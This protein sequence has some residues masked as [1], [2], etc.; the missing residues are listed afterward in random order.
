MNVGMKTGLFV[1]HVA[2]AALALFAPADAQAYVYSTCEGNAIK[3]NSGWTNMHI[4]TTS[5][6]AGSTWDS[7]LQNA[8]WHWNN[9]KGSG[10]NYYVNRDTDGSHNGDNGVNEIY[11][12]SSISGALAVT[13]TR[14]HCYWLFGYQYG[15]DET[16]IGFNSNY[17]WTTGTYSYSSPTGSPYN[18]EAV[19]LHE[20][21]HALGLKHEDARMATMNSY[22]PNSGPL[23][24]SRQ[25]DPFGD[26]R[27]GARVLYPD[28]TG[29][30]DVAGSALKRTGT[31]SSNLVSS[32]A[33]AARGSSVTIE[34]TFTNLST[35][36]QTF[37]IGF[38]LS[39]NDIISTGDVWLGTNYGAWGSAG[40]TG[41][42]SRTV[43]I[44]SWVAPGTYYL[45]FIPD[46]NNAKAEDNEGN[47]SQRMPRAIRIY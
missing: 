17:S 42:F 4:S 44:P 46:P 19:A 10:F 36:T 12:D 27:L 47:N 45:G 39:T 1:A 33:S 43:T 6:P 32:P 23:G 28:G 37:D 34:F 25:W 3:W 9:V 7:R 22:Y 14:Y 40:F 20:L 8:M 24:S 38:Y 15:I 35:S 26:D 21:G 31:G 41:T 11:F 16:D 29:E 13:Y 18:F 5:M 2:V 30:T